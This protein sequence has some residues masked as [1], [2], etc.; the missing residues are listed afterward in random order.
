M[1]TIL[2]RQQDVKQQRIDALRKVS[3]SQKFTV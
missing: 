3:L 1:G 2:E